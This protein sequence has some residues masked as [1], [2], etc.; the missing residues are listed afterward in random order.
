MVS[1]RIPLL[2][3]NTVTN[4][5]VLAARKQFENNKQDTFNCI[6]YIGRLSEWSKVLVSRTSD[7][8][9]LDSNPTPVMLHG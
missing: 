8:D 5:K 6:D 4:K 9:D 2:S 3:C 7:F 1:V